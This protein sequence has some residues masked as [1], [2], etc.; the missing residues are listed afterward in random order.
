MLFKRA[1]DI[2]SFQVKR[3]RHDMNVHNIRGQITATL[4]SVVGLYGSG[5]R[6]LRSKKRKRED[7]KVVVSPALFYNEDATL[8]RFIYVEAYGFY[9]EH[10]SGRIMRLDIQREDVDVLCINPKDFRQP[11][12]VRLSR[13]F[14]LKNGNDRIDFFSAISSSCLQQMEKYTIF[15]DVVDELCTAQQ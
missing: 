7:D 13:E 2:L 10:L 15:K 8:I 11:I 6:E 1:T 9:W 12:E 4:L 5:Q 3:L 14:D